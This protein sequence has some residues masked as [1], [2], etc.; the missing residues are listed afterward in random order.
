MRTIRSE[1]VTRA[2]MG[3]ERPGGGPSEKPKGRP[4]KGLA[5]QSC[6]VHSSVLL[7]P[8]QRPG[9]RPFEGQYT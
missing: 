5:H 3:F 6:F 7:R 2:E 9:G 8:Y 1:R 4:Y